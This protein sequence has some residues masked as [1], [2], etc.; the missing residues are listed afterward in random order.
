MSSGAN[1]SRN[2]SRAATREERRPQA[3]DTIGKDSLIQALTKTL[4]NNNH[5]NENQNDHQPQFQM[6]QTLNNTSHIDD[7]TLPTS[8]AAVSP[9]GVGNL[10]VAD[11]ILAILTEATSDETKDNTTTTV[12][13][14]GSLSPDLRELLAANNDSTAEVLEDIAADPSSFLAS[15]MAS[16]NDGVAGFSGL[17]TAALGSSYLR[18]INKKMINNVL[19]KFL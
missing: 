15:I 11:D 5:S 4:N 12:T 2:R 17:N 1:Q 9:C 19:S 14:V 18:G 6:T 13:S 8:V 3:I 7:I 16:S 10:S